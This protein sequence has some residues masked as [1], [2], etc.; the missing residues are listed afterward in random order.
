MDWAVFHV[1]PA[2]IDAWSSYTRALKQR[3]AALRVQPNEISAWDPELAR[4]G[5]MIAESRRSF[6]ER[7]QPYWRKAAGSLLQVPVELNYLR[8]WAQG[9]SLLQ[10]LVASRDRDAAYGVTHAGPHRADVTLRLEG[11]PARD[12]LSRGEQK[13]VA[14]AMTLAQVNLIQDSTAVA[15]TLLLDD[16]AAELDRGKLTQ[17]ADQISALQCQLVV[18]A[19]SADLDPLGAPD[20]MFHVE[21]GRVLHV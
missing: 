12:L 6:I 8:G 13:L 3:N 20:R 15:P 2:F 16:P 14:I 9:S 18:T 21:Q 19:L 10:A 1:E 4:L 7:L 11:K 17:F 5:E